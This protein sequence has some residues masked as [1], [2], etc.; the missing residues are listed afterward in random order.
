MN[1]FF[2]ILL[3]NSISLGVL[4]SAE[5]NTSPKIKA[6]I[7]LLNENAQRKEYDPLKSTMVNIAQEIK[8]GNSHITLETANIIS[9][10]YPSYKDS[11]SQAINGSDAGITE[12][13]LVL[14]LVL[15]ADKFLDSKNKNDK[16][17]AQLKIEAFLF[18]RIGFYCNA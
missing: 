16:Y 10:F 3:V 6:L 12:P 7:S 18:K 14:G 4:F 17:L 9:N 8:N 1:K 15:H 5:D 13:K 11:L 2:L